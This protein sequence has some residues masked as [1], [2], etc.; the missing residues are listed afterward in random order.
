MLG[1]MYTE[2]GGKTFQRSRGGGISLNAR[3]IGLNGD[4]GHKYGIVGQY[5]RKNG[6]SSLEEYEKFK[7]VRLKRKHSSF[8]FFPSNF[9]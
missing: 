7:R 9:Y 1:E 3:Y 4:G 8:F 5:G 6:A 2:D